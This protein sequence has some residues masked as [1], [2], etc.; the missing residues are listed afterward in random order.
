MQVRVLFFGILRDMTGAREQ[1]FDLPEG[2]TLADVFRSCMV[3][4]PRVESMSGSIVA[5]RNQE[6]CDSAAIIREGDEIAMLP[7]V[8]GGMNDYRDTLVR[9]GHFF[10]LTLHPIDV[11][12]LA[13]CVLR[14]ADGAVI[15]FEGI[16]RNN[17]AGRPVRW[18]EYEA[19]EAMAL[20]V[21]ARIGE[22]TAAAEQVGN[23]AIVHRL[24]RILVGETSIVIVVGAPH[25]EAAFQAA[26]QAIDRV[27]RM[28][29]IWKKECF[30]DG[31][32]WVEGEWDR[33]VPRVDR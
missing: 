19:Y 28:A 12:S 25:R 23:I 7:P 8:S 14:G 31:E 20:Q 33:G 26:R 5:A 32:V 22:E 6:F 13:A 3:R 15:T 16:V 4:F 10:G 17:T 29:P 18:L 27:K 21:M 11:P 1:C 24:G 30:E 9:G 2:S